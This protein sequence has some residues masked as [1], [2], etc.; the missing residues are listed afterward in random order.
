M[1]VSLDKYS[2]NIPDA[3]V[4]VIPM[5]SSNDDDNSDNDSVPVALPVKEK[6]HYNDA[7]VPVATTVT[8]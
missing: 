3:C 8:T 2:L 7:S 6:K 1:F 4:Q 5:T